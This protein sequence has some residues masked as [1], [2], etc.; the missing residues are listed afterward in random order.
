MGYVVV[1]LDGSDTSRVALKEAVQ[2][3]QWREAS[4]VAVHVVHF[5]IVNAYT[6]GY[7]DPATLLEEGKLWL[8]RELTEI[9]SEY[10]HGFP[11][12]VTGKPVVGHSGGELISVAAG[13]DDGP[14]DLLVLGS[15]GMGGFKGLLLGSVTTYAIHH[16]PCQVLVVP[17]GMSGESSAETDLRGDQQ[18]QPAG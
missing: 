3:A 16:A 13:G 14:A 11:V 7:L 4:V 10:S 9:E 17:E 18:L 1:G 6:M 12:S 15:R 2:N 8:D 5:P